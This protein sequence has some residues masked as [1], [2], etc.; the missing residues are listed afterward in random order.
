MPITYLLYDFSPYQMAERVGIGV[1]YRAGGL[2]MDKRA[3]CQRN[4]GLTRK[5]AYRQLPVIITGIQ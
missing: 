1:E 2:K 3:C 4:E 5:Q